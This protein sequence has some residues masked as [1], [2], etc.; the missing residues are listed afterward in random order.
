M[1]DGI[2]N[3]TANG[4]DISKMSDLDIGTGIAKGLYGFDHMTP[5]DL[6]RA[7]RDARRLIG[8]PTGP[9]ADPMQQLQQAIAAANFGT[10]FSVK[11][12]PQP[13]QGCRERFLVQHSYANGVQISATEVAITNG[14]QI[15]AIHS[16]FRWDDD[17]PSRGQERRSPRELLEAIFGADSDYAEYRSSRPRRRLV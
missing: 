9:A 6:E 16:K 11:P 17:P 3:A 13:G 4:H 10:K 12:L 8:R 1:I 7:A 2:R 14:G 15:V 5:A